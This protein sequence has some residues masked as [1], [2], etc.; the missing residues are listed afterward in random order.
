MVLTLSYSRTIKDIPL[1]ANVKIISSKLEDETAYGFAF[2]L[3]G[4]YKLMEDKLSL[5]L[6][7]QNLGMGLKFIDERDPLPVNIKTGA[8]YKILNNKLIL[9]LDIN[10]PLDYDFN[11]HIG[12]EYIYEIGNIILMPRVG[13]KTTTISDL[14][15]LSGLSAGFGTRYELYGID[16]AWVPYGDLGNTHRISINVKF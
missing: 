5:G 13:Y 16:Y 4:L 12:A 9:A 7:I 8:A 1:G 11:A 15:T 14:D 2:D 10:Y 6:V 3:G